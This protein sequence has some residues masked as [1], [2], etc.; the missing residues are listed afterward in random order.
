[1]E[2][3]LIRSPINYT[4]NKYKLL[5][6]ILPLFPKKIENFHDIFGGSGTVS[7][8]CDAENVFYNDLNNYIGQILLTIKEY[9]QENTIKELNQIIDKYQ[10]SKTNEDGFKKLRV[11]YNQK[12]T[13]I[14]LMVLSYYSFNFQIRFNNLKQYN[15]SF[16]K[17]RSYFS[18]S[19][20][21]KVVKSIKRL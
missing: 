20:K 1:M 4:G 21:D 12:P 5:K 9:G 2:K 13:P 8:N 17:N 7:L 19:A 14:K 6:Q 10:L 3:E 15:S 18:C 16:G 11:D